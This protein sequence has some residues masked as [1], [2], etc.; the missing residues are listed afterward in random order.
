VNK[1]LID[2]LNLT[3]S[4]EDLNACVTTL[5]K[6]SKEEGGSSRDIKK[7]QRKDKE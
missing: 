6:K 7:R 1:E 4:F 2:S 5:L 3:L